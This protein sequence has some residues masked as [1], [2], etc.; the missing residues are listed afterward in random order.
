MMPVLQDFALPTFN[1]YANAHGYD[2]LTAV[3]DEDDVH[4]KTDKA[5]EARWRKINLI[6]DSL[7]VYNTVVWFDAD[8]LITRFDKDILSYLKPTHFQGFVLQSVP[9]EDRVNPNSGVWVIKSTPLAFSFLDKLIKIGMPEGRWSD[10]GAILRALEWDMGNENYIGAT[11]PRQPNIYTKNTKWLPIGWNQPYKGNRSIK[12]G[13]YA[14]RPT[15]RRPY[16]LHFMGMTIEERKLAMKNE[17]LKQGQ[18]QNTARKL[19]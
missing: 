9:A 8:I 4:R 3:L 11:I 18:I 10:Q 2:V 1:R 15:V 6:R 14:D 16:V 12:H 13:S 19:Y 5:K 17:A 7:K